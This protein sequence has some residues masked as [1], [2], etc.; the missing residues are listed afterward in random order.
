MLYILCKFSPISPVACVGEIF[1]PR[2][3]LLLH[4]GCGD[5]YHVGEDKTSEIF[6][7]YTSAGFSEN[8]L[9]RNI[10]AIQYYV[11]KCSVTEGGCIAL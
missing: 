4:S 6:I 8:F 11:V 5:L 9:P 7:Q 2:I 3:V 1:I 10:C